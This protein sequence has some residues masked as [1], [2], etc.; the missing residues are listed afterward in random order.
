VKVADRA[1]DH[2]RWISLVPSKIVQLTWPLSAGSGTPAEQAR[3]GH[4]P[5]MARQPRLPTAAWP[6][7]PKPGNA[8]AIREPRAITM[9]CEITGVHVR[10][11]ASP[12]IIA[13]LPVGLVTATE[14]VP[15]L[16]LVNV[17]RPI[18]RS[19]LVVAL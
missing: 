19:C 7:H 18:T 10:L 14:R 9:H 12:S 2:E 6:A 5:P 8:L 4:A 13:Y 11:T 1:C 15:L 3:L 16:G 17:S